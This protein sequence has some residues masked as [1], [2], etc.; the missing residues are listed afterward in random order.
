MKSILINTCGF[1]FQVFKLKRELA[2][3]VIQSSL[4]L[5]YARW[6]GV[7]LDELVEI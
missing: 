6:C 3:Q 5:N 7:R 4:S 1:F 2:R